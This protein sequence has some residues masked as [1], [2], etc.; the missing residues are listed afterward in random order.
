MKKFFAISCFL[1]LVVPMALMA[2]G[3]N[4]DVSAENMAPAQTLVVNSRLWSPPNEQEYVINTVFKPFQEANNCLVDFTIIS[5]EKLLERAQ[6][7]KATNNV[8]TDVVIA[9]VSWFQSWVDNG[10]VKDLTG[11]AA[12]WND[13]TFSKGF[14][15]LSVI[16]GR[17]Y[18]LPIGADV[19]LTC[20]NNEALAYLPSGADVQDLT[21]EEL[22]NWANAIAEGEGEGKFGWTGVPQKMLVYQ[23][24]SMV[25]AYGGGFPDIG[26]PEAM[27]A[28]DQFVKMNGT[29][30]PAVKTYDNVTAPMKRGEVWLTVTHNGRVGAIY[31]SN[32]TQF[33][34]AAA[35]KGPAGIGSIAGTSGLGMMEGTVKEELATAFLEYMTRPEV[36]LDTM[37]GTGGF[38]PPID[39]CLDLLGDGVKDE[40]IAKSIGVLQDGVVYFV[41]A[42]DYTDWGA[43]KLVFDNAFY[44]LVLDKGEIDK[45]YIAGAAREIESLKK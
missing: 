36:M 31:E 45:A 14:D 18:F 28:W 16:N 11:V 10:Y 39:E 20:A 30:A 34:V 29:F 40:I 22:V 33:T 12:S 42:A 8:T 1:V 24:G 23:F 4:A 3:G 26:S 6:V 21:W 41:P 5:D 7:Q 2:G 15:E 43:V 27:E 37:K 35:P 13:R 44:N 19:Y 38:I 25:L 17:R 9:Y 32:P